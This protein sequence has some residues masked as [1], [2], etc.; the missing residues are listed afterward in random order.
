MD[1]SKNSMTLDSSPPRNSEAYVGATIPITI[2]ELNVP[3]LFW[4]CPSEMCQGQEVKWNGG[5]AWCALCGRSNDDSVCQCG[6]PSCKTTTGK[7]VGCCEHC[8]PF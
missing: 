3:F 1:I 5:K 8:L 4:A 2:P 6:K 7:W